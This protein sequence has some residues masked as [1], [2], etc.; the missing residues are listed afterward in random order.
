MIDGIEAVAFDIDGT[1][2][3]SWKL[4]IR[5]PF[6]ILRNFRFYISYNKARNALHKTAPLADFYEYQARLFSEY[7]GIDIPRSRELIKNVSY[8]GLKKFFLKI[9]PYKYAYECI[10]H[11]KEKGLKIG[12]LSDFPPDQ[13]GNIWGIRDLCDVCIG[14]EEAGALKPSIYPFGILSE[15]LGVAPEKILYVGNSIKYD[16]RG[17][18]NAGMK[19]AYIL[20]GLKRIFGGK[21]DEADITF[22]TYRQLERAVLNT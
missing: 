13:K 21:L 22:K 3:P 18:N 8:D 2:Y 9:K 14:S 12:I 16:V 15:K 20:S 1:L 11:M 6:Y 10:K 19:S 17:A 7:S 5:M 4:Y